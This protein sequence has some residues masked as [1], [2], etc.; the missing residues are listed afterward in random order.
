M[1]TTFPCLRGWM[2]DFNYYV[3]ICTVGEATRTVQYVEEVDDWTPESPPELKLQRKLNIARVEREMVP[4]LLQN[5][6][7][8]YGALTVEVRPDADATLDSDAIQFERRE[9]FPGGIEF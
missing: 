1:A 8:F 9:G 2:G 4:Y 3:V 5:H 7:H 6:D